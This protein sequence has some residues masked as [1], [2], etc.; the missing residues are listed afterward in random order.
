MRDTT[1]QL[2]LRLGA[3]Q[4]RCAVTEEGRKEGKMTIPNSKE[5][6]NKLKK[7]PSDKYIYIYILSRAGRAM[8]PMP[9][10]LY[11]SGG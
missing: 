10:D 9:N 4:E 6:K 3:W 1:I 5:E 8:P 7:A 11:E 2:A